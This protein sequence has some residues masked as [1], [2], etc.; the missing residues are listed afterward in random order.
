M[1]KE[2]IKYLIKYINMK[3]NMKKGYAYK[4]YDIVD[5]IIVNKHNVLNS[6]EN[7]LEP[8]KNILK[9][10]LLRLLDLIIGNKICSVYEQIFLNEMINIVYTRNRDK[11]DLYKYIYPNTLIINRGLITSVNDITPD[12]N[13]LLLCFTDNESMLQYQSLLNNEILFP[14]SLKIKLLSTLRTIYTP[15]VYVNESF[16]FHIFHGILFTYDVKDI[17]GY[18]D[19]YVKTGKEL[20]PMLHIDIDIFFEQLHIVIDIILNLP[21]SSV[22]KEYANL[23]LENINAENKFNTISLDKLA[24]GFAIKHYMFTNNAIKKLN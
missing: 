17:Y 2:S 14:P 8:K 12:D 4:Q 22:L 20:N 6:L 24:S 15:D 21:N 7:S 13:D 23:M 10:N 18:L 1:N 9:F 3:F 5:N 11:Q 19:D 16:M